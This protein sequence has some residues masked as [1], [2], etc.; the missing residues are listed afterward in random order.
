MV[1]YKV[2]TD[3]EIARFCD[4]TRDYN[5]FHNPRFMAAQGK[6][7]IVPG[8][9]TF[10]YSANLAENSF[11]TART[12]DATMGQT[13]SSGQKIGFEVKY[14]PEQVLVTASSEADPNNSRSLAMSPQYEGNKD[15]LQ[16]GIGDELHPDIFDTRISLSDSDVEAYSGLIGNSHPKA[17]GLLYATTSSAGALFQRLRSPK[18]SLE[19]R[20]AGMMER[21]I[22]PVYNSFEISIPGRTAQLISLNLLYGIRI[23]ETELR[24]QFNARI[25]CVYGVSSLFTAQFTFRMASQAAIIRMMAQDL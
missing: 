24:N 13:H 16:P 18:G 3:D 10:A 12:L 19:E 5:E 22:V 8:M 20:I 25:E 4:L 9:L 1:H 17:S 6:K 15:E 2:F 21:K 14:N 11:L 7:A 23:D